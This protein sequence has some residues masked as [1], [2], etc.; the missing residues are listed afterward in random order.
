MNR[1]QRIEALA[2]WLGDS[3]Q[4]DAIR[5]LDFLSTLGCCWKAEDQTMPVPWIDPLYRNGHYGYNIC[6][7]EMLRA[8]FV[9]VEDK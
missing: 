6:Q 1:E 3:Y 8:G 4:E 9:K 5:L 7:R 2:E